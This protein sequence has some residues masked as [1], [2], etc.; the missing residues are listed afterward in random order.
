MQESKDFQREVSHLICPTQIGDDGGPR[1]ATINIQNLFL[2]EILPELF[3]VMGITDFQ[4]PSVN[5]R[6]IGA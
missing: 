2:K 5:V 6:L 1:V 3:C 4:Y